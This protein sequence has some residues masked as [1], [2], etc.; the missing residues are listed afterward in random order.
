VG[1]YFQ[2]YPYLS[3]Y[4]AQY[5]YNLDVIYPALDTRE[6]FIIAP[7]KHL[8]STSQ[9]SCNL[10]A[11]VSL[12][13][14][15]PSFNL[16]PQVYPYIELYPSVHSRSSVHRDNGLS[17]LV[18][19]SRLGP[20]YPIFDIYPAVYP[21]FNIYPS[22]SALPVSSV[23]SVL[24]TNSTE[25]S[26]QNSHIV[27]PSLIIYP[28][29]YPHFDL[30]PA[31][32]AQVAKAKTTHPSPFPF[33]YPF[34]T[35]YPAVYPHFDLYPAPSAQLA[36]SKA[37]GETSL[38]S[39]EYPFLVIYPAVYP[40]FDLYPRPAA[41]L[42]QSITWDVRE[43]YPIIN[44][45]P[46]V[47]PFFDLYPALLEVAPLNRTRWSHAKLHRETFRDDPVHTP[48]SS[49]EASR[50]SRKTHTALH[51]EFFR[52]KVVWT[53][54]GYTQDI[55]AI[56]DLVVSQPKPV[57][58]ATPVVSP[59]PSRA[60]SGTLTR[61]R[62]IPALPSLP[63]KS[64]GIPPPAPNPRS[65]PPQSPPPRSP[66]GVKFPHSIKSLGSTI[67]QARGPSSPSSEIGDEVREMVAPVRTIRKTPS[68]LEKHSSLMIS[69]KAPTLPGHPAS[70]LLGRPQS[71]GHRSRESLVLQRARAYDKTTGKNGLCLQYYIDG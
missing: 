36:E 22:V 12:P 45:Y 39:C 41:G 2:Q 9:V 57:T 24:K 44:I 13:V 59:R 53:P 54:S 28:P 27:Y 26:R 35:I 62:V 14:A 47:Y 48:S 58:D 68:Q 50:R 20:A 66:T 63:L 64:P 61:E 15:Y 3:I 34:I 56:C 11:V 25:E 40:H 18:S 10:P 6:P 55:T 71:M 19:I 5:P 69:N 30:Y 51:D 17:K 43:Q 4:P 67:M 23:S 42:A 32:S 1:S 31:P 65:P 52:D 70:D 33:E 46:A 38:V 29:V 7:G 16:Y 60:R 49:L 21:S 8:K 37:S